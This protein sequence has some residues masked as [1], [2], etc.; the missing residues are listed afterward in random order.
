M[1]DPLTDRLNHILPRIVSDDFL[2]G[3]GIG[4]EIAFY[5]FDYPPEDEL[6]V[7]EHIRSR[8]FLKTGVYRAYPVDNSLRGVCNRGCEPL[9]V[10]DG[11]SP[12]AHD[13]AT[14]RQRV[15]RPLRSIRRRHPDGTR[16]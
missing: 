3:G 13:P 15:R 14:Y 11:A 9:I 4:N 6:R 16:T 12:H 2:G 10:L 5:V 8:D 7:R 1:S